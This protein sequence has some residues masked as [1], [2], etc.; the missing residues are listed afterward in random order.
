MESAG[1]F[2]GT[3]S[4]GGPSDVGTESVLYSFKGSATDGA[5]P[6]SGVIADGDGLL[7]GM[8]GSCGSNNRGTVFE[9]PRR[10]DGEHPVFFCG[11]ASDGSGPGG[12]MMDSVG[13][14]YGTTNFG[15]AYCVSQGGCGTV[16]KM[17]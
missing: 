10:G 9:N 7:Y 5:S 4:A 16:F 3:T 15:G 11:G 14:L 13:T 1:I 17:N 8:T 12:V 2:Y 6:N